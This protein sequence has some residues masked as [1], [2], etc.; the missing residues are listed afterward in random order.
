MPILVKM[1]GTL[2]IS[3]FFIFVQVQHFDPQIT[4]RDG[5]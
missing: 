4:V 1:S 3:S 5:L 2:Q